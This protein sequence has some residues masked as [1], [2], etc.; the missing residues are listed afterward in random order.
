MSRSVASPAVGKPWY[1]E[2]WPWFIIGLI[3]AAVLA[4]FATLW[5]AVSNPD[6]LVVEDTEYDTIR[7]ELRAQ[8]HETASDPG[9]APGEGERGDGGA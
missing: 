1:R 7:G 4:S 3:G 8:E 2:P 5:I 9:T 6:P